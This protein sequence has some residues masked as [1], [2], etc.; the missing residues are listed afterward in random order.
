MAKIAVGEGITT[1]VFEEKGVDLGEEEAPYWT[2][3]GKGESYKL[4]PR[5]DG[6]GART[7][8]YARKDFLDC[9]LLEEWEI[10]IDVELNS[11]KD[12]LVFRRMVEFLGAIPI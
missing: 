7:L 1:S 8:Y 6:I 12:T 5:S 9:H 10:A 4:R 11:F 3:L 2:T